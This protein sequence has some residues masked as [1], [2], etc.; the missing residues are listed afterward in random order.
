MQNN[1]NPQLA[2]WSA[3]AAFTGVVLIVNAVQA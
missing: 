2:V 1:I 3:F